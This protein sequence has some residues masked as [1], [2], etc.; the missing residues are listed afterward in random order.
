MLVYLHF[1]GARDE[2]SVRQGLCIATP[3]NFTDVINM[4]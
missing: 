4:C 1:D 2:P 3:P